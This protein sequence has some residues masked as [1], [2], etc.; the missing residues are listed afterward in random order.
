MNYSYKQLAETDVVLMKKLLKVFG[1]AFEDI[2]SY[3]GAVPS[4]TYL[5]TLLSKKPFIVVVALDESRAVVGGLT[6][7]QLDKF[8]QD[9]REIY[10]YD[11]AVLMAHRR[12]GIATA[13]INN[14]RTIA[15][16]RKAY[17]IFVQADHGD[18]PAIKLYESLGKRED[19][20]HFD[21]E[22]R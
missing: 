21:I 10:I 2:K 18:M 8:E 5:R 9:R 7:Y 16:K 13:L 3:Q 4:D 20:Y 6:A 22:V 15:K 17:V 14:L 11:L 12:K 19:V 1:D